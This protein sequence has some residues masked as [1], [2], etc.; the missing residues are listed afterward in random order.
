MERAKYKEIHP[1]ETA[2][3]A[4][5]EYFNSEFVFTEGSAEATEEY[6]RVVCDSNIKLHET[7]RIIPTV[8]NELIWP[9]LVLKV[10]L[11]EYSIMFNHRRSKHFTKFTARHSAIVDPI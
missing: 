6:N 11:R 1:S 3:D 7:V 2:L 10:L 4:L 8:Y 9:S 5:L